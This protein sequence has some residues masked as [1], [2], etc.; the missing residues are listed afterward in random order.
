VKPT[1]LRGILQYI[2]RYREK[3]FILAIDGAIVTDENFANILLDIAVLRSLSIR[4]VLVHGA[5]AQIKS[6]AAEQNIKPS[7]IDGTGITD[8]ATLKLALTASNRLTHEILEGL[9]ANDLRA[10]STN[11]VIAHPL[12]ILQ[13]VDHLFTGKVERVDVELLQKLMDNGIVPVL[14]P[15]GFDGDGR[16]YR[17]NSDGVALAVAEALK[18]TKLMFITN[19]DGISVAGQVIRQMPIGDLESVLAIQRADVQS[20]MLSKAIHA[21]AACKAGVPRV[22][23]INGC[24]DEG[25]LAEVFTNEGIGTLIYANEFQQIR[26]AMKKDLRSIINLT[27]ISMASEE[28]VKRSRPAIEKQLPDY[29]LFEIDKNP[30]AC[31]A[32]HVYHE[33][34]KGELAFLYVSASHENQGIGQKLIQFVENKAREMG[35][36]ELLTLSTQA[37]TYFQSKGGFSEGT[38]DDLPPARREKYD[39]SGRNSK[40]LVKK[41]TPISPGKTG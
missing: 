20:A 10:A 3:T 8:A 28:L 40:V 23:V 26:R 36:N 17:V 7:D 25:L 13:G 27:K 1:D 29:Y 39:Q 12:G 33:Q 15:L 31:V 11:A 9:S 35:L 22:H 34:K 5:S 19:Q 30:V 38:P 41:L 32:L 14:P 16:T 6:L 21:V 24:V 18:A 2:P 37:F 4:V